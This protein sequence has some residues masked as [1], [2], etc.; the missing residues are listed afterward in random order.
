MPSRS[1]MH[2]HAREHA[3]VAAPAAAPRG[4]AGREPEVGCDV[5]APAAV[6]HAEPRAL[7]LVAGDAHHLEPQ[8]Q[9]VAC[10]LEPGEAGGGFEV[11]AAVLDVPDP[12]GH[13]GGHDRGA[14]AER[15]PPARQAPPPAPPRARAP[16]AAAESAEA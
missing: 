9:V 7:R 16:G 4:A 13:D 1:R 3:R 10:L 8:R 2:A 12:G 5:E 14:I 6:E 11:M 15:A